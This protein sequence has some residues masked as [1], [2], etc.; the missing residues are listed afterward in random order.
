MCESGKRK[1][2]LQ[3]KKKVI[4]GLVCIHLVRLATACAFL[5]ARQLKVKRQN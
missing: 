3:L 2:E 4:S 5:I 1:G